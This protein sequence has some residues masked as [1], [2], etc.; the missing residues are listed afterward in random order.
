M[1][2]ALGANERPPYLEK[3]LNKAPLFSLLTFIGALYWAWNIFNPEFCEHTR[4]SEHALM[5]GIVNEKFNKEGIYTEILKGLPARKNERNEY[6]LER[7]EHYRIDGYEQRWRTNAAI[8]NT[9]GHGIVALAADAKDNHA[10]S[11]VVA[12]AAYAQEQVYWARDIFILMADGGPL[13][14]E[15][16]LSAFHHTQRGGLVFDRLPTRGDGLTAMLA[17]KQSSKEIE[18]QI[19][20]LNGELPN[21]DYVNTVIRVGATS[22]FRM[23][24]LIYGIR[25]RHEGGNN[26]WWLI[27]ARA[28]YT[29]A[30]VS[31]EGLHS[32]STKYGVQGLTIGL[33]LNS[34]S[35][36]TAAKFVEAI[37]RSLNN[38]L[39]SFH[40]SYFLYVLADEDNFVSILYFMPILGGVVAPLAIFAYREWVFAVQKLVIPSALLLAHGAGVAVWYCSTKVFREHAVTDDT[41]WL[42]LLAAILF[43]IAALF[44]IAEKSKSSLRFLLL[45]ESA[46]I[47]GLIGLLNFPLALLTAI[48]TVPIIIVLS[49]DL[50]VQPRA[51]QIL[52]ATCVLLAHPLIIYLLVNIYVLPLIG[53]GSVDGA[54]LKLQDMVDP[55]RHMLANHLLFGCNLYPMFLILALPIW[56]LLLRLSL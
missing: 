26:P 48:L 34:G 46:L 10:I 13:G 25:D 4:I 27:P 24:S 56:G 19:N 28:L 37:M 5:G 30:F 2:A 38:L 20:Q 45:L 22:K 39:E 29:Q 6:L 11:L 40:Q 53:F 36:K 44:P 14:V 42:G 35:P 49:R 52:Q 50:S 43:P 47:F 41:P 9:S 1:R 32:L 16:F 12:F 8:Y 31:V 33:P 7:L 54:N 15:A 51:R 18:L 17:V 21:L 3:L 23:P 55:I